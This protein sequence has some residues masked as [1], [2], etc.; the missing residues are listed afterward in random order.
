MINLKAQSLFFLIFLY[1]IACNESQDSLTPTRCND[2]FNPDCPN[3]DPCLLKT[4]V[5]AQYTIST[6]LART[7][8]YLDT[9][10]EDTAFAGGN[11]LFKAN[12]E[13][14]DYYKWY[15]GLDTI[16]GENVK[17]VVRNINSLP[18]GIYTS[19]LIITKSADTTCFPFDDGTDTVHQTFSQVEICDLAII[20]RFKGVFE[21][22]PDDTLTIELLR[23][24]KNQNIFC[25]QWSSLY[26]IN[27]LGQGDTLGVDNISSYTNTRVY[28]PKQLSSANQISG[29]LTIDPNTNVVEAD[30][31]FFQRQKKF[32]GIVVN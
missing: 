10:V 23:W 8:A 6:P 3:Y 18:Y 29:K 27:F 24:N 15:L 1:V 28:W 17:E 4:P 12:I 9:L 11:I 5:N 30:Y 22:S 2:P 13:D 26:A 25:D 20:N 7:G 32:F 16:E 31:E 14:A 21:D 19:S